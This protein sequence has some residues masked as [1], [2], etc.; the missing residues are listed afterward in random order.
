MR[1]QPG[2][3]RGPPTQADAEADGKRGKKHCNLRDNR[4]SAGFFSLGALYI[5]SGFNPFLA[6]LFCPSRNWGSESASVSLC[7]FPPKSVGVECF[8]VFFFCSAAFW[9]F[10]SFFSSFPCVSLGLL[11]VFWCLAGFEGLPGKAERG[12]DPGG[13]RSWHSRSHAVFK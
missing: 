1:G 2:G 10:F 9:V 13:R 11:C 7:F 6:E 12:T 4:D 8:F 3:P 5:F